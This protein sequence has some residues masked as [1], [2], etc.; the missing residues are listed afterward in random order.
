MKLHIQLPPGSLIIL[1]IFL[2]AGCSQTNPEP[3]PPLTLL[4]AQGEKFRAAYH[5]SAAELKSRFEEDSTDS[6]ALLGYAEKMVYLYIFGLESKT[7]TIPK[8]ERSA[9]KAYQ[10]DSTSQAS[11]TMQAILHFLDWE[12]QAAG[13]DFRSA[14]RKDPTNGQTRHWYCLWL[15]AMEGQH[16]KALEHSDTIMMHDPS[17]DFTVGRGSLH[18]FAR[19]NQALKKLMQE[20]IAADPSVPWPYDWL[21]MAHCELKEF[22]QSIEIYR[23]AF[24]LS[25]GLAEVGG[26]LGHALGLAGEKEAAKAMADF[27][28]V[29]AKT[30][31]IPQVQRAFIH[32]GLGEHEEALTLLQEAYDSKSWFI[33]FLQIEPWY[34][35]IESDDRF[36]KLIDAMHFPVRLRKV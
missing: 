23:Q 25:D 21:G 22:D 36:Q 8:A 28:K 32:I 31:Y 27:Y 5:T 2:L 9:A 15:V 6:E 11:L 16:D 4:E 18:Y 34:D 19:K 20:S 1:A 13:E 24:L 17:G 10:F 29:A 35:P 3:A 14:I 7:A 33:I 30:R 26:G 12:W